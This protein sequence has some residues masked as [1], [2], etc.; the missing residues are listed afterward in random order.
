MKRTKSQPPMLI[1]ERRQHILSLIQK[2][3]RVLVDELSTDL[4][5]SKITIR[6]DLDYLQ[7]KDLLV[8]THGGALPAQAGALSDPTIQEKEELHHEEKVRI[9]NAAAAMVSEGQ[10]IILDSGTTTTEI[11]RALS[12]FRHLTIITNALN[13]AADLSRS[14]F[15]IIL[16]G[17]ALRKNSL[18][19]VGPLAEDVLKEM[20]ADIVFL[21][22]DGFD[23]KIGLTTP[24][25]L[26]ARVNRA[27]VRASEKV[28][29]VCDSSKFNRRSLS[30]IVGA[31]AIDHVIT[32]SNLSDEDVKAIRDAGI[33]VTVV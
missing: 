1:E 28:V 9:A 26:E 4:S 13:I 32:D 30:L 2:H 3:G 12:S 17:G 19:V 22:V 23:T 16:T 27:M 15:E 8:R 18:S 33:E 31:S 7:S 20:H 5:L 11:A 10:C 14:D 24:N 6:K 21:G 25:V 29:A